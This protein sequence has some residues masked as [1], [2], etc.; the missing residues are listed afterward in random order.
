[1]DQASIERALR[2]RFGRPLEYFDAIDSTQT[3]AFRLAEEG[4]PEGALVVADH[5]TA[6]RGRR[7]R[8]WL[9]EPARLLQ[10]SLVLRPRLGVDR[11]GLI[12]TALGVGVAEGIEQ[13]TGLVATTKWPNDVMVDDRKVAGILIET[14][15]AGPR[16]GIAVAGVGI[17]VSWRVEE[18]PAEIAKRATSL[19]SASEERNH[20]PLPRRAE[21]LAALLFSIEESYRLATSE[22]AELVKRAGSRSS[23]LGRRV[24]VRFGDG[25]VLEGRASALA[26]NGALVVE[27]D[28]GSRQIEAGEIE[29][30]RPS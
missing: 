29:H 11:L 19:L 4:A 21:I 27:T 3:R 10:F 14:R 15:L 13:A 30:I 12:T 26:R 20:G 25:S 1:M 6:G 2:G 18:L 28:E 23:V 22:P 17:N 5:Q 8:R 24:T 9:S 16:I 7:G